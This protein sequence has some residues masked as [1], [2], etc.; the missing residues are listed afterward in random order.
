MTYLTYMSNVM[1]A[2]ALALRVARAS[3]AMILKLLARIDPGIM[4]K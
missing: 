1:A 3:A 4:K 2:D